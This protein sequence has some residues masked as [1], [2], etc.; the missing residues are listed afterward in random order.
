MTSLLSVRKRA[1]EFAAAVDG[2]PADDGA[3]GSA[4]RQELSAL[5]G[6]V[7]SLR[8]HAD[9]SPRAEFATTLR[10]RLMTEA[11]TALSPQNARLALPVRARGARERRLVAVASAVVLIGGTA[12]MAA[13]AQSALPGEALYPIKRG[14][15]RAQASLSVSPAGKGRDLLDQAGDR[16]KEV[17]GLLDHDS[18]ASGP[19]VPQTLTEFTKQAQ[20]G[21]D[22]LLGSFQDTRDPGTVVAVRE[23]AA[24][25]I[26]VLQG[27]AET[28]PPGAQDE[29]TRAAITLR[30]I[31]QQA[32]AMCTSC[33][34]ALPDLELPQVFLV[35]S[36]VD[37]AIANMK[38]TKL[39]N[40]HPVVAAKAAVKKAAEAAAAA[41]VG[42]ATAP[43]TG[44]AAPKPTATA[45]SGPQGVPPK[46]PVKTPG[47][48]T[49]L[50]SQI[51]DG[52]GGVVET[53]L[54][55]VD[56]NTLLP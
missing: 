41:G 25:A 14:I 52:L 6:V 36:E 46:E 56:P 16:L 2:S 3:N 18:A 39:N 34:A 9:A 17:Q 24:G 51:V 7:V 47:T 32:T 12:S 26:T 43:S 22:L 45:K 48:V 8:A 11:E 21:S 37:R 55:Q 40:D 30:N 50:P 19:A 42:A 54:P 20:E 5:V 38:S 35:S 53:L 15:E 4:H 28:A 44:P 49:D 33:A 29:L 13:A 10:D 1:E 27:L 31:D 23:F